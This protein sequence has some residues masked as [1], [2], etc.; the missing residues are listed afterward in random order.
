MAPAKTEL[1]ITDADIVRL[2][3]YFD[4][5]GLDFSSWWTEPVNSI[6][7]N[8]SFVIGKTDVPAEIKTNI[9]STF[10][11]LGIEVARVDDANYQAGGGNVHCGTNAAKTPPCANFAQC[12]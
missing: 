4:G 2:P 7:V 10:A 12:P 9:E 6:F 5:S 3:L 8:G 1:G 11:A